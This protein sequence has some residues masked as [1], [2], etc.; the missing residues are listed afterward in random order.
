[1][2]ASLASP[3]SHTAL[4]RSQACR[5]LAS[6]RI[7]ASRSTHVLQSTS[8]QRWRPPYLLPASLHAWPGRVVVHRV[9]LDGQDR[10]THADYRLVH[11]LDGL[12]ERPSVFKCNVSHAAGLPRLNV[13]QYLQ[14]NTGMRQLAGPGCAD[15]GKCY[16]I[17]KM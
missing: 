5:R 11:L 14:V 15:C 1:M 8:Q 4:Y 10:C 9:R 17:R 2:F 13:L 7:P 16:N 12:V 3:R 6:C